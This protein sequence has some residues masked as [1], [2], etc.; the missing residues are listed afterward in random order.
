MDPGEVPAVL[1]TLTLIE[2]QLICR[3]APTMSVHLLGHGGIAANG[4]CVTFPQEVNE[5]A[6]ILPK[7]P[8]EINIIRV[9]KLGKNETS[10][11]FNIRRNIVQAALTWLKDNNPAYEDI[12]ISQERL[13]Q[14]PINGEPDI[15]T[16]EFDPETTHKDDKGP[17]FEQLNPGEIEVDSE[18][19]SSVLLPE[20]SL[21]IRQEVE[22]VVKEV[23]GPSHGDVTCK[24]KVITIPWPTRS[25]TPISEFTTNYFFSLAFPCLFPFGKGDFKI[26]RPNTCSSMAQW[27]EHL[28]WY[29]DG[30]FAHHQ[31]FKFI[32]HNIIMR[33]RT[34]EHSTFIVRQHLGD[35]HLSI[36][37]LRRMT[38][39]Q[40]R[41]TG[42]K[43]LYFG[44]CLRGSSQYWAQR[45]QELRS[46][47]QFQINECKGLPSFF[48]TGSCAEFYF[49][50]LRRL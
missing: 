15:K 27:A 10:K 19:S 5:P 11:E 18:T 36:E 50:P 39:E 34:L 28:L 37:E 16:V 47:I 43:I 46:F 4:H 17:A 3:I 6:K 49:K 31:F 1:K 38:E 12:M 20:P 32:V 30:R 25:D 26:N 8:K 40:H 35:P 23:V 21:D 45:S 42:N 48:T 13:N 2:Q 41:S 22:N 24:R 29:K 9:R 44:A 14:L 7:L 33:K